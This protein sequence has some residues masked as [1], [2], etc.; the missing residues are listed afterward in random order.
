MPDAV[1]ATPFGHDDGA[2]IRRVW[3]PREDFRQT[4]LSTKSFALLIGRALM[5][6][7]TRSKTGTRRRSGTAALIGQIWRFG[8]VGVLATAAHLSIYSA[9]T[10]LLGVEPLTANA[11]AFVLAFGISFTGQAGWTFRDD[12]QRRWLTS[13]RL[14]RFLAASVAGFFF[15]TLI[16]FVIVTSLGYPSIYAL[17]FMAT[18]VPAALFLLNR[19]WVFGSPSAAGQP[20]QIEPPE[21]VLSGHPAAFR[22]NTSRTMEKTNA[23]DRI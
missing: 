5:I 10:E 8:T 20:V 18:L 3:S 22:G 4:S 15:N 11:I 6:E 7:L 21:T 13:A 9:L 17:P 14:I 19:Y 16:V 12:T 1:K 2:V 23:P